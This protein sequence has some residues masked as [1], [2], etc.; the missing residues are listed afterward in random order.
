MLRPVPPPEAALRLDAF[1]E[2]VQPAND[3][4]PAEWDSEAE[5]EAARGWWASASP[6]Q[7]VAAF[8]ARRR[9]LRQ[10]A[11][12]VTHAQLEYAHSLFRG[13]AE[14]RGGWK[15][16]QVL[17]ALPAG[18]EGLTLETWMESISKREEAALL[19]AT[20]AAL[21]RFRSLTALQVCKGV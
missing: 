18:L 3:E 11:H 2:E 14:R 13:Q 15:L 19:A 10:T 16:R 7:V 20:S 21:S 17:Q 9:Q 8:A 1:D 5:A 4:E 12:L 6:E